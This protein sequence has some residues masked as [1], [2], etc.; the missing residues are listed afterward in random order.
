MSQSDEDPTCD[1][2]GASATLMCGC[3]RCK[4]ETPMTEQYHACSEHRSQVE[5]KHA[6]VRGL[7]RKVVWFPVAIRDEKDA[8]QADLRSS[9]LQLG[10]YRHYKGAEYVL[11][12]VSLHEETLEPLV[13]Y[14]S[15]EKRTRWTR[16]WNNFVEVL[17][18]DP[19][20]TLGRFTY[21]RKA[22]VVEILDGLRLVLS[23]TQEGG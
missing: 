5:K 15:L 14:Y 6:L 4:I 19:R 9:T 13:H 20:G 2:C 7:A 11:F 8:R 10:V 3:E 21:V 23:L 12:A 22:T 18:D 1:E 17:K 16:S